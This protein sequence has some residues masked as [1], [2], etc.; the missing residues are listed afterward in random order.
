MRSR[1]RNLLRE[2][3][4]AMARARREALRQRRQYRD[5]RETLEARE[6]A[7]YEPSRGPFNGIRGL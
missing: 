1:T 3:E 7:A 5:T 2:N 4:E 6:R